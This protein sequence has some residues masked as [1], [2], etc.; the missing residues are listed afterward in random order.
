[1]SEKNIELY[2]A[3]TAHKSMTWFIFDKRSQFYT[4]NNESLDLEN[5]K[6][7]SDEDN[8]LM[9]TPNV[10]TKTLACQLLQAFLNLVLFQLQG[11][12]F[13]ISKL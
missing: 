13:K 9:L 3:H 6:S 12:Y 7:D 5:S 4:N 2:Q 1:M 11:A 10:N 8:M